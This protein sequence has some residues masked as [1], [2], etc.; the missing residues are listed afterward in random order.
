[1]LQEF[2]VNKFYEELQRF[3]LRDISNPADH[4]GLSLIL[5]GAESNL[6]DLCR[7]YAGMSSTINFFNAN[8]GHYRTK[9]FAELNY[10]NNLTVDFGTTTNQKNILGAGSIWLT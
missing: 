3:K 1:M 6:W 4:Y 7:T 5:G 9:E 10:D 2:G 8:N